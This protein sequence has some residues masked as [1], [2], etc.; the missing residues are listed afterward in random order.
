MFGV[1]YE[2]TVHEGGL[3]TFTIISCPSCGYDFGPRE[4]R[5]R[6]FHDDHTPEDFGLEPR[7]ATDGGEPR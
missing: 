4:P 1:T 2:V 5:W 7:V 6:H 3:R